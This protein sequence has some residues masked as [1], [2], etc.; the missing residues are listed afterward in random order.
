M[1]DDFAELLNA[2]EMMARLH[3]EDGHP[4]DA[5]GFTITGAFIVG[6]YVRPDGYSA[7]YSRS[8][9][10]MHA[11]AKEGVLRNE[12]RKLEH[13]PGIEADDGA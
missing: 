4:A 9:G 13:D 3:D 11:F 10:Q 7:T 12:L 8:I 1:A 5:D 6:L 2:H